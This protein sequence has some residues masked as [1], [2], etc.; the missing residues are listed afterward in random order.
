MFIN[1]TFIRIDLVGDK[2]RK[3]ICDSFLVT[4]NVETI[5]EN[6]GV[7]E[8]LQLMRAKDLNGVPIIDR[9]GKLVSSFS[10]TDLL[11]Q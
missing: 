7:V 3:P 4:L 11:V 10:S 2:I 1:K 9:E 6:T 8:A 5:N